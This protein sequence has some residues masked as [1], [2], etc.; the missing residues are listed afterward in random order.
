[1]GYSARSHKM[2]LALAN[3]KIAGEVPKTGIV[4]I[5]KLGITYKY[6]N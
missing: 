5:R 6:K 2:K 4:R 3:P 1:M